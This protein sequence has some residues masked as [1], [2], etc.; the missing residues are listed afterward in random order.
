VPE[1]LQL[2]LSLFVE[3]EVPASDWPRVPEAQL[4]TVIERVL[5]GEGLSGPV[6]MTVVITDDE[7]IAALNAT[8]RHMEGPTDVLSFPFGLSEGEFVSPP[9]QPLYLGDIVISLPRAEV[10]ASEYG[11]SLTREICYL[12][13]H[14][15]LHL[16]GY[17]H[18]TPERQQAMRAKEEMALSDLPRV[19][20]DQDG[21]GAGL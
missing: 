18:D 21:G 6:E 15:T 13:V 12:A 2:Q 9:G 7:G 14:G 19:R 11:H 3:A 16:L 1:P 4:R 17:E 20:N 10:Q 5:K 8:Y